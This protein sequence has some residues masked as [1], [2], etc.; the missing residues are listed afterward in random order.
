MNFEHIEQLNAYIG[1]L[2]DKNGRRFVVFINNGVAVVS[3][4]VHEDHLVI[5][6]DFLDNAT[7]MNFVLLAKIQNSRLHLSQWCEENVEL[8]LHEELYRYLINSLN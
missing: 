1:D 8:H 7:E 3:K 5:L 6:D 4:C 2:H